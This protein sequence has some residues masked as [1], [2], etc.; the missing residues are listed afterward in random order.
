MSYLWQEFNIKTFPAQTIVFADGVYKPDLSENSFNIT[1][2]SI[3]IDKKSDL[4]VHIIY[5]GNISGDKKLSIENKSE[6]S[7]YL[8][9]KFNSETPVFLQLLIK[10]AGK[11]SVI[12][13]QILVQNKSNLK[14]DIL[15]E[16]I[17]SNT[18]IFIENRVI[19][20][21]KSE[22]MLIATAKI[23]SKTPDCESDIRFS[24]LCA[25]DIKKIVFAPAQRISTIPITAGHS[26][27][28]WRGSAPQIEYL[29]EGGLGT[30]EIKSILEESFSNF[31]FS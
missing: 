30:S 25:P 12:R 2:E 1:N 16:H 26:A 28:I 29:R 10:N 24:A 7:I 9:A 20:H 17:S 11:N 4:P 23:P 6:N 22:T 27:N 19:A 21:S 8:S 31:D 18:S 3:I 13:G 15:A 5:V 14:L